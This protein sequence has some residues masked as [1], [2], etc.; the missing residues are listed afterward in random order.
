MPYNIIDN[1]ITKQF[2]KAVLPEIL[3]CNF[4]LRVQRA[5]Y[6]HNG[7]YTGSCFVLI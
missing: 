5:S 2:R 7:Y 1:Q 4:L 3:I 6:L